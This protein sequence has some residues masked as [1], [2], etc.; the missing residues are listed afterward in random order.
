M[1]VH[2]Q[3]T[4][5]RFSAAG[6][7]RRF[8]DAYIP[9]RSSLS[10][11][12]LKFDTETESFDSGEARKPHVLYSR[13]SGPS[14]TPYL[15]LPSRLSQIWINRWT[16]L[17]L[18]VLVRLLLLIGQLNHNVGD[19]KAKAL[20]ACTK[21][22][23]IG[24]GMASMPHYLSLGVNELAASGI[25]KAVEAMVKG[26]DLIMLG[27]QGI[28]FF[29]I[30]FITATYVCLITA[31]VH[32]SLEL[33][34]SV[35]EEA[36]KAFNKVIDGTA[37]EIQEVANGLEKAVKKVTDGIE[38][39][40]IGHFVPDI[41]KVDFSKPLDK[42]K[43]FDLDS[44]DFAKDVRKLNK[45][46]P[47]FDQV[48]NLTKQAIAIPFDL[49]RKALNST[50]GNYKFNRDVFPQAQKQR[51]TFCSDNDKLES[52]FEHLFGL[53]RK[54]RVTFAVLLSILAAAAMLPMAWFEIRRWR[55]Q[56]K[57]AGLVATNKYDPMD[58]IYIA[59]RPVTAT[60]GIKLASKFR[61]RRQVLMRWGFAYATSVPAIF[62]L[63][64]A[65][66]GLFSCLCQLILLKVV[67][68]EIPA[69]SHQVG[70]FAGEGLND[71]INRDVLMYV[72]NA[73]DAVNKTIDIFLNTM[74]DGLET[75]FNGTVLLD[76]IKSVVHCVIGIK[77]ESVQKG[78]TW[79]H[80]H[81]HVNFPLFDNKTFS[82]GAS[83]SIS[84]DSDLHTFLASPSS[85]TTDE[86]SGAVNGVLVWLQNTLAQEAL[87]S[88]GI[89]L[90]YVIVVLLGV[91]RT[92]AC[93][94]AGGDDE[95]APSQDQ[96]DSQWQD[97]GAS[98]GGEG[99][100]VTLDLRCMNM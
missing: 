42:L 60:C 98:A 12:Y 78:L 5:F 76:P 89:L 37:T 88:T 49:A 27:V 79:V 3:P 13:Q 97:T 92:L 48:Q 68:R 14:Y 30:N 58:V 1:S 17:L 28:I 64:L 75:V 70:E 59:S 36:T 25:E 44:N 29:Y 51:L 40:I 46:L 53:L 34:A 80:N 20:S 56:Q 2:L 11:S 31:L 23:D 6:P 86:V 69:V 85:V 90:I 74:Q 81:A 100:V 33:V 21:V 52:F 7:H 87:I 96:G 83:N 9:T 26:L 10:T 39:S 67:E 73:T 50:L 43:K 66:A 95:M 93:L 8:F 54:T 99:E 18:L 71:D 72:T 63:S 47:N 65:I 45:D 62:V 82:L 57:H 22:E 38:H 41:P 16:I 94:V 35:T 91:I 24:S 55:R 77:L 19:A 4:L 61:G 15:G 84:G 32:G